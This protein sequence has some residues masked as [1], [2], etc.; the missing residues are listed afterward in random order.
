[1]AEAGQMPI[2]ERFS[3]LKMARYELTRSVSHFYSAI[4][5]MLLPRIDSPAQG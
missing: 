1:M 5:A 4:E 2:P 3:I